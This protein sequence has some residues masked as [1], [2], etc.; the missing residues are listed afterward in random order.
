MKT[1]RVRT[2]GEYVRE[3]LR[4]HWQE[5]NA[6]R[7]AFDVDS[8][9]PW[10]VSAGTPDWPDN[11]Q[12]VTAQAAPL[13]ERLERLEAARNTPEAIAKREAAA[14]KRAET[15]ARRAELHRFGTPQE[16]IAEWRKGA[17]ESILRHGDAVDT[18]GGNAL[19]RVKGKRLQTSQGVSVPLKAAIRVFQFVKLL[20]QE[21][22]AAVVD[23]G[24]SV[25]WHRNGK[26]VPVGEFQLDEIRANGTFKAG[27]HTITWPEIVSAA[28]QAGV[29]DIEGSREAVKESAHV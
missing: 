3:L 2:V 22:A 14:A 18:H 26:R 20:R 28:K 16:R 15:K 6:Y 7:A 5:A 21:A 12:K 23:Y 19:L 10:S 4:G 29:L 11:V 27:C 8:V 1:R 17:P 13:V 24:D 25:V 9:N